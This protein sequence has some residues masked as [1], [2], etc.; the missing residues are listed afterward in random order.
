MAVITAP[1]QYCDGTTSGTI[2]DVTISVYYL[3]VA[4]DMLE[5]VL[6]L[7][8][9]LFKVGTSTESLS[10]SESLYSAR[11]LDLAITKRHPSCHAHPRRDRELDL[12]LYDPSRCPT[13]MSS[14]IFS[15]LGP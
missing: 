14:A 2:S 5:G 6:F 12:C 13:E 10:K 8:I 15:Y 7:F 1:C 11:P 3:R 4:L 9:R